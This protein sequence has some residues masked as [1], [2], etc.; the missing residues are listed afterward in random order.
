MTGKEMESEWKLIYGK[1][2][3]RRRLSMRR[4]FQYAAILIAVVL[5]GGI[6]M[7]GDRDVE[8]PGDSLM[9]KAHLIKK[10]KPQAY[11][12][13]GGRDDREFKRHKLSG[14]IGFHESGTF[15]E[16]GNC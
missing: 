10:I 8:L 11:F 13:Y 2:I 4:M 15:C 7:L 5:I 6:W 3:G 9:A 16:Q 12:G 1:T 14:I